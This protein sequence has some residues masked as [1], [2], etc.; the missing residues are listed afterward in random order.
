MRFWLQ[1]WSFIILILWQESWL[2]LA[3]LIDNQ[4]TLINSNYIKGVSEWQN[5]KLGVS[6]GAIL[7]PLIFLLYINDLP[8]L[9]NKSSKPISYMDDT[10]ILCSNVNSTKLVINFECDFS[11]NKWEAFSQFINTELT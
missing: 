4:R 8:L 6:Q 5:I 7:G 2:N 3:L 1:N 9:I 10:S 11:E